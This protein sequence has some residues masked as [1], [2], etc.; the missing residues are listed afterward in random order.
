MPEGYPEVN[1]ELQGQAGVVAAIN[2]LEA[3]AVNQ[4]VSS[5][6][7][8]GLNI[9]RDGAR[10]NVHEVTGRTKKAIKVRTRRA[11]KGVKAMQ[12]GVGEAWFT[13]DEFYAAFVEF[14]HKQGSRKLGDRRKQVPGE[15]FL[16]YAFDEL[17]D[18]ATAAIE[19]TFL[20]G[21]EQTR[22]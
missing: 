3:R 20:E 5:S 8:A 21:L 22:G 4:L 10:G 14:G 17:K 15:H 12:V 6:L 9:I 1:L 2:Q 18:A 7:R 13:G 19:E 16:E 11:R